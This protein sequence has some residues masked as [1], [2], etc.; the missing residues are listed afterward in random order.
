MYLTTAHHDV[1]HRLIAHHNPLHDLITQHSILGI[2]LNKLPAGPAYGLILG[3]VALEYLGIP[4]PGE[5]ALIAGAI[6]AATLHQLSIG[7]VIAAATVGALIG[8]NIG[9]SIGY[10]GGAP[11]LVRVA[12][13]LRIS[14][15]RLKV[16]RYLFMRYGAGVIVLGRFLVVLR[17]Y[18]SFLGGLNRMGWIRFEIANLIGGILWANLI[19]LGYYLAGSVIRRFSGPV[20]LGLIVFAVGVVLA[21]LVIVRKNEARLIDTAERALPGPLNLRAQPGSRPPF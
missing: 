20:E 15:G 4:V 12:G 7:W 9:F 11:V 8:G 1:I 6:L 10:W 16:G 18:V 3:I 19:G 14:E 2:D 17:A 5:T 13:P 21:S